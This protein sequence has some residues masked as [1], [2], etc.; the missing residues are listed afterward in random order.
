MD[1]SST[2]ERTEPIFD[3]MR[4]MVLRNPGPPDS[5]PL[6]LRDMPLPAP[7]RGEI[8]LRVQACGVCRTDLHI[9]EGELAA[10]KHD[11]V[12][13]HQVV[14]VVDA[15]GQGSHP[16]RVGERV[17]ATWL[18]STCERCGYCLSGKE[19]LCDH[20]RFTGLHANGGFAE[21]MVIPSSHAFAIP[22]DMRSIDAAPLLCAGVIG[23]RSL[24]LSGIRPRQ[25]LGLFG[26]GA[27]AHLALQVALRWD[28][29]VFVFTR[30]ES[31]RRQAMSL[32]AAWAGTIDEPSPEPYHSAITFAPSG[33]VAVRALG[34]LRK[35]GTVA[36]NAIHMDPLP[37]IP[38]A[39][40]YQ[41]RCLRSVANVTRE[42]IREFLDMASLQPF[43]VT[44]NP[45]PLEEANLALSRLKESAFLGA[46]VL[47]MTS[48]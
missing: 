37:P 2:M 48:W 21:S 7:G 20:A 8:R 29:R 18:F 10:A 19:N 1:S 41:E 16:F 33:E 40:I 22:E 24:K 3:Q 42:D 28:C 43:K 6:V 14:G 13:G 44:V 27:S 25:T 17:G 38:F 45:F 4:A 15:V 32:G 11:L 36:I 35:G 26:F 30:E 31:R 34:G 23:Y 39:R 12:P 9:A 47:E 46:A 5:Q